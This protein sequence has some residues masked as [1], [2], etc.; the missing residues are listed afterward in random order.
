MVDVLN[1]PEANKEEY[2]GD[3]VYVS[4]DGFQLWLRIG[5]DE[6]TQLQ[7]IALDPQVFRSLVEYAKRF[8]PHF[9]GK[10]EE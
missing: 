7:R 5:D 8:G 9:T 4:H 6:Y 1:I 2:I 3:G 10:K